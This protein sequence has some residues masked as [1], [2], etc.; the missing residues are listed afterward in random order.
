MK[1]K[2]KEVLFIFLCSFF[3]LFAL[4]AYFRKFFADQLFENVYFHAWPSDIMMQ[5]IE[6]K[7]MHDFGLQTLWYLHIQPPLFDFIRYVLSIDVGSEIG[8]VSGADFDQRLYLFYV[9]IYACFNVL[10]FIWSLSLGLNKSIA[11]GVSLMWAVYPGNLAMVTL[12]ESTYLSAFLIAVLIFALQETLRRR[13]KKYFYLFLVFFILASYTRNVFQFQ[14]MLL[15]PI[16][17]FYLASKI[18]ERRKTLL[19]AAIFGSALVFALPIKQYLLFGTTSTTSLAGQHKIE[20][21]WYYPT[22]YELSE[23]EV[24]EKFLQNSEK[25]VNKFNSRQQVEIN[26]KYEV[27]FANLMREKPNLVVDGIEKSTRQGI[28]RLNI[29]TQNYQPN[30]IVDF[31][32]WS[33]TTASIAIGQNY[34]GLGLVALVLALLR[35]AVGKNLLTKKNIFYY[36]PIGVLLASIFFTILIGSH[37]YEWTDL[38]RLKFLIEFPVII[39]GFS[40]ILQLLNFKKKNS[41]PKLN[42]F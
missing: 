33:T 38:E 27:L 7:F 11:I 42:H 5:T 35:L 22:E 41:V 13:E 36:W 24:N 16:V 3:G 40:A 21:I 15:L 12:L 20:G 26:Y 2:R 9:F 31:L 6:I 4:E 29:P 19:L 10:V 18:A 39:Y 30:P 8:Y 37:R 14:I 1:T 17:A 32:P 34:L 25:Y 23:I 28:Q